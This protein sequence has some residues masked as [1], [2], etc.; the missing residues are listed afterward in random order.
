[1]KISSS[2]CPWSKMVITTTIVCT[3]L[4][5]TLAG[6]LLYLYKCGYNE[7]STLYVAILFFIVIF[8][9]FAITPLR[10]RVNDKGITIRLMLGRK[11]IPRDEIK[12]IRPFNKERFTVR[13]LGSGGLFGFT[14]WFRNREIGVFSALA[15]DLDK[16]YIIRRK[17]QL[18]IMISVADPSIFNEIRK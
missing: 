8:A 10:V 5:L 11:F 4:L 2:H 17:H 14:G 6:Y 3:T 13:L 12:E 15:T 9:A 7:I 16:S 1:M 18:P